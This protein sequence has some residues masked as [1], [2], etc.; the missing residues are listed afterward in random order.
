[1]RDANIFLKSCI[2]NIN[3][4]KVVLVFFIP[5]ILFLEKNLR[6]FFLG[7]HGSFVVIEAYSSSDNSALIMFKLLIEFL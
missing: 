7:V 4:K 2:E 6:N 5:W 1:M 3:Q